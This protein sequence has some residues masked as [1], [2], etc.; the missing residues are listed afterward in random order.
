MNERSLHILFYFRLIKLDP[1]GG[2]VG[3]GC[4]YPYCAYGTVLTL[5]VV[6]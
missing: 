5:A 6:L 3:E 2:D 1:S 4:N